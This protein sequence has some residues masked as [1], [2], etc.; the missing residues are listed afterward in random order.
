MDIPV[1]EYMEIV[2]FMNVLVGNEA[3][4]GFK[5]INAF[6]EKREYYYSTNYKNILAVLN[7]YGNRGWE[8]ISVRESSDEY[9]DEKTGKLKFSSR[10]IIY[11][12]KREIT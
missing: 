9:N 8:V 11:T 4:L 12:L 10:E 5:I 2:D 3:E 1:W 7:D 6:G